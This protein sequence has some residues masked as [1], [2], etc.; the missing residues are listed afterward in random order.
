MTIEFYFLD[1]IYYVRHFRHTEGVT[2]VWTFS[3][4]AESSAM[5]TKLIFQL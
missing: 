3:T 2:R 4:F 5:A 1:G